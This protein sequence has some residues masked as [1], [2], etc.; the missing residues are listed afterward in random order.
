M[1]LRQHY[2]TKEDAYIID[3]NVTSNEEFNDVKKII[4][5]FVYD[6]ASSEDDI[7][8]FLNINYGRFTLKIEGYLYLND[9]EDKPDKEDQLYF[10]CNVCR[11][12]GDDQINITNFSFDRKSISL[13]KISKAIFDQFD[14]SM[15]HFTNIS[16]SIKKTDEIL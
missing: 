10:I 15:K 3:V 16:I 11:D 2:D 4:K 13:K 12:K 7:T 5:L 14:M 9:D 1:S 8:S 6:L